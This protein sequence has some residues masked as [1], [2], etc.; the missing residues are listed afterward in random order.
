[1][2]PY[3]ILHTRWEDILFERRNKSYGAYRLR[4]TSDRRTGIAML[5]GTALFLLLLYSPR[6]S[7]LFAANEGDVRPT[8]VIVTPMSP[9]NWSRLPKQPDHLQ[10]PQSAGTAHA[11]PNGIKYTQVAIRRDDETF[12]ESTLASIDELEQMKIT[13][14]P[15]SAATGNGPGTAAGAGVYGSGHGGPGSYG[16][17]EEETELASG[18]VA[19]DEKVFLKVEQ[20]PRFGSGERELLQYLAEQIRYPM[21]AKDN[22]ISG[23]VVIQF[24]IGPD[25]SV[26][27]PLI[28]RG[29]GGGCDEE[30]LRVIRQMPRWSPGRQQGRPVSVKFTLPVHFR[31]Q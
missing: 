31:L 2:Q 27:E 11:L 26:S 17:G 21:V 29:I 9:D 20:M 18:V 10:Q 1:M 16:P 14:S 15:D 24:V 23:T 6:L 30:A 25:G 28:V 13:A 12:L 19:E 3:Q 7:A 8:V 4:I 22:R 5:M